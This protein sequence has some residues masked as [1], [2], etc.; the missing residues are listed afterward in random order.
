MVRIDCQRSRRGNTDLLG[1]YCI[2]AAERGGDGN[3]DQ[4]G[5]SG[6]DE[7]WLDSDGRFNSIS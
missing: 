4:G 1:G 2:S 6:S 3:L 5:G 7:K